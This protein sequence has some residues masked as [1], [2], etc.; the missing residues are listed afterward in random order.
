MLY[1][2][3]LHFT[4]KNMSE[5]LEKVTKIQLDKNEETLKKSKARI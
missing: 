3:L 4:N 5:G 1:L 2:I